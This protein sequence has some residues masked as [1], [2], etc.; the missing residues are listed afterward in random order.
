MG[1]DTCASPKNHTTSASGKWACVMDKAPW[2]K[3]M[4]ACIRVHGLTTI[5]RAKAYKDTQIVPF[6][7]GNGMQICTMAEARRLFST[8]RVMLEASSME[9]N[10][11]KVC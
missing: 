10:L 7:K 2:L 8:S 5:R 11:V 4:E 3:K 1:W 6:M 9:R